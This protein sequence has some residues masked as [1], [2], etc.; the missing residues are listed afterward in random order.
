M[1]DLLKSVTVRSVLETL[2]CGK[3]GAT[4]E[5][6]RNYLCWGHPAPRAEHKV[7]MLLAMAMTALA[8]ILI[9]V[10]ADATPRALP[11]AAAEPAT[12]QIVV[13]APLA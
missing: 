8:L 2:L 3:P 4:T 5:E 12:I 13:R 10:D 7:I 6:R 1:I 11:A 9:A